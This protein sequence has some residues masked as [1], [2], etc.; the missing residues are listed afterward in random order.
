MEKISYLK[1]FCRNGRVLIL[2]SD[3]LNAL[4]TDKKNDNIMILPVFFNTDHVQ[5]RKVDGEA[6]ELKNMLPNAI[7]TS[8]YEPF[9]DK[10]KKPH[11]S[12]NTIPFL[13][14][15]LTEDAK[16]LASIF[17]ISNLFGL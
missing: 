6:S 11:Y 15:K 10:G 3:E 9:I 16:K 12:L 5:I 8:P 1:I 17:N 13:A 14:K 7:I 4:I 2:N